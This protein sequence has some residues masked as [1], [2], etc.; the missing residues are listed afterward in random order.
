MKTDLIRSKIHEIRGQ[1]V[2]FDFD[3]AEIYQVET[4]YLKRMV[5]RNI[6][7]FPDDFMFE[8]TKEEYKFLR[9]NFG[10]LKIDAFKGNDFR[11]IMPTFVSFN[12]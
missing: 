11:F 6:E 2:M 10:T 7:R 4:K 9:C 1:M 12:T 3:S 8:L 5:R